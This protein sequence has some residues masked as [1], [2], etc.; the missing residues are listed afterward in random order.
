MINGLRETTHMHKRACS[1][2]QPQTVQC[3]SLL[4]GWNVM[5]LSRSF[6]EEIFHP[7]KELCFVHTCQFFFF[8]FLP[9]IYPSHS[10]RTESH[11]SPKG[12]WSSFER[13]PF[14]QNLPGCFIEL[15]LVCSAL[16]GRQKSVFLSAWAPGNGC[17]GQQ[18]KSQVTREDI[19][20]FQVTRQPPSPTEHYDRRHLGEQWRDPES[21]EPV[22]L[23]G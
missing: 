14:N 22:L 17:S 12:R 2:H 15:G 11:R 5:R 9:D 10:T 23:P 4:G 3:V 21:F 20:A 1:T 16:G 8:F 19:S 7:E 6:A 18:L 13:H